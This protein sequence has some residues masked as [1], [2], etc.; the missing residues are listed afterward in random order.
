M[1][2]SQVKNKNGRRVIIFVL[3]LVPFIYIDMKH[4]IE[5]NEF[6]QMVKKSE[7]MGHLLELLG[8]I[9]AGGNYTTLK[10][11]IMKWNID[12][13]HWQNTKRKRQGYKNKILNANKNI[14]IV[15]ILVKN[16]SYAGGTY[17]LKEK[18]FKAKVFERKCYKCNLVEWL[19]Q[20]IPTELEHINGDRFDCRKEN[21]TILCP[22][23]HAQTET[24]RGKNKIGSGG[25]IRTPKDSEF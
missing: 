22:N 16:S 5:K 18:L 1:G 13:S 17:K 2:K 23:C 24:Y 10:H 19:G 7:S 3:S 6:E 15:E 4:H 11:R 12:V 20:P 25:G 9:K 8:I 14:P 21:L